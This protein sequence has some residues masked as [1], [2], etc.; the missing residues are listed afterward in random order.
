MTYM[1]QFRGRDSDLA[2][3]VLSH[4]T[5]IRMAATVTRATDRTLKNLAEHA[6]DLALLSGHPT[7]VRHLTVDDSSITATVG[8]GTGTVTAEHV[9]TETS[10]HTLGTLRRLSADHRD[11][12]WLQTILALRDLPRFR[13]SVATECI[14]AS[15]GV[16]VLREAARTIEGMTDRGTLEDMSF[17]VAERPYHRRS[18]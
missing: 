9:R 15:V 2:E 18:A 17:R 11:M 6:L 7:V 1:L 14:Y 10:Q 13:S 12:L 5:S 8:E 4:M 3:S 16:M